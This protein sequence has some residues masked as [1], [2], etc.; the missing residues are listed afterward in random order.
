MEDDGKG[1]QEEHK[2]RLHAA[3]AALGRLDELLVEE[4]ATKEAIGR[5]RDH[6]ADRARHL[7]EELDLVIEEL[8]TPAD[9]HDP[10]HLEVEQRV[11]REVLAAEREVIIR[12]RDEGTI[13]DEALRA[14]ERDLDLEELRLG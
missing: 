4:W 7:A 9:G 10:H 8:G 13:G 12:L 11:R 2:A 1:E 6:Y 5:I 14:I 3:Q